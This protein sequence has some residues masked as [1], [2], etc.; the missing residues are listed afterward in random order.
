MADFY[1]R[2]WRSK[3]LKC[4]GSYTLISYNFLRHNKDYTCRLQQCPKLY[5]SFGGLLNWTIIDHYHNYPRKHAKCTQ[6]VS[7]SSLTNYLFKVYITYYR[8]IFSYYRV[9]FYW[10]GYL[11]YRHIYFFSHMYHMYY[12]CASILGLLDIFHLI[13]SLH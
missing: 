9:I 3:F 11:F 7:I 1:A 12:Y 4:A 5:V 8:V 13:C 6:K 10:M 2:N